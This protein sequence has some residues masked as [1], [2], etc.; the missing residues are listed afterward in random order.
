MHTFLERLRPLAER[1]A[2]DRVFRR[3]LPPAFERRPIYI[4]PDSALQYLKPGRAG[5][6]PGLLALAEEM[7]RPGDVVWDIGANLGVFTIAALARGASQVVAV[8][9]DPWLAGLIRRSVALPENRGTPVHILPAAV[10]DRPSV[11]MLAIAARGRS[12]NALSHVGGRSQMGGV[13]EEVAVPVLTLDILLDTFAAPTFVKIDVEGAEALVLRGAKRLLEAERKPVLYI[14]IDGSTAEGIASTLHAAGYQIF[15]ALAPPDQRTPLD[16]CVF[17][18]LA[19][20]ASFQS[21]L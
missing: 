1:L 9:P 15:D 4:S 2:R 17:D 13:R 7:V 11:A 10:A 12:S 6:D 8:E 3:R 14:E 21:N 19:V 16:C 20:P 18:T 5:F